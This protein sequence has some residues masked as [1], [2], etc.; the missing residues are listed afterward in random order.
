[1]ITEPRIPDPDGFYAAWLSAHEG[2]DEARS[3]DLDARLVLLLAN[4]CGDQAVLLDC[5]RAAAEAG[6][7][8]RATA[9]AAASGAPGRP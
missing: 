2:L 8:T 9:C 1:M 7:A 4:Q 5:I 3:A 6:T